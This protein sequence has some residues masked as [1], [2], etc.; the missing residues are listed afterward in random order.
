MGSASIEGR[1]CFVCGKVGHVARDCL[2]TG[3]MCQGNFLDKRADD[4]FDF[5]DQLAENVRTWDTS[6]PQERSRGMGASNVPPSGGKFNIQPND[7]MQLKISQLTKKIEQ[8]ELKKVNEVSI[9][10]EECCGLCDMIDHTT[11][12]CSNIP[13]CK[14]MLNDPFVVNYINQQAQ[15]AQQKKP[16]NSPYSE[17]YNPAWKNH[18]NFS[19]RNDNVAGPSYSQPHFQQNHGGPLKILKTNLLSTILKMWCL[20]EVWRKIS[21]LSSCPLIKLSWTFEK[22]L[23]KSTHQSG[24]CNKKKGD[25]RPNPM[26]ILR[27]N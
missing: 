26:L 25:F 19:W 16:Q 9:N 14:G 24:K 10:Q 6:D 4:A 22:K 17:S 3:M 15:Q 5:L 1:R 2:G 23:Q 13:S 20:N 18:P 11:N 27:P 7:E 8:L 12:Q 21:M